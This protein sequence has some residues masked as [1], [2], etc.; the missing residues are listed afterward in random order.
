ML[1]KYLG[2]SFQAVSKWEK[3]DAVPN[4]SFVPEIATFFGVSID[5]LFAVDSNNVR[6]E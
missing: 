1:A 6:R 2:V 3:G 4:I 5:E